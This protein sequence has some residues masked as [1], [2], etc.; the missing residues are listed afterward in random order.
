MKGDSI[1]RAL[2]LD[3]PSGNTGVCGSRE[4]C[5]PSGRAQRSFVLLYKV[6]TNVISSPKGVPWASLVDLCQRRSGQL[7]SG[8][9]KQ[10]SSVPFFAMRYLEMHSI[11][12]VLSSAWIQPE[13]QST[14][15]PGS[16]SNPQQHKMHWAELEWMY[17]WKHWL[18]L[19]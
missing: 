8:P 13:A 18:V 3:V 5:R 11:K 16:F 4:P 17:F 14:D 2:C 12:P 10:P 15:V 19:F 7:D 1:I 6:H 9:C